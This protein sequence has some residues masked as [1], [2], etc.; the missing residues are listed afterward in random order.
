MQRASTSSFQRP[1]VRLEVEVPCLLYFFQSFLFAC[2]PHFF[3]LLD[4]P[5]VCICCSNEPQVRTRQ[6]SPACFHD[7][8]GNNLK[9]ERLWL[10]SE[11]LGKLEKR[12]TQRKRSQLPSWPSQVKSI[13]R[14]TRFFLFFDPSSSTIRFS[15]DPRE[16]ESSDHDHTLLW[17]QN[18]RCTQTSVDVA[19]SVSDLPANLVLKLRKCSLRESNVWSFDQAS[20][21]FQSCDK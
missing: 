17:L 19:L 1:L 21:S 4:R 2:R 3:S 13:E 15:P 9:A 11:D 18:V 16:R 14:L 7:V 12:F 5:S 8:A 6:P 10:R 20:K